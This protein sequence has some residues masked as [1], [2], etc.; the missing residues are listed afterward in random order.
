[1]PA[2]PFLIDFGVNLISF[3]MGMVLAGYL[4]LRTRVTPS[5]ASS[6][7]F[8]AFWGLAYFE[9]RALHVSFVLLPFNGGI[10]WYK[11]ARLLA[12]CFFG[13]VASLFFALKNGILRNAK[14]T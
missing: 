9:A 1:M 8:T 6:F 5:L 4:G 2:H 3:L 7:A 14:Q 10:P 11:P 12:L 13:F